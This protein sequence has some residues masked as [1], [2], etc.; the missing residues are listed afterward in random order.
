MNRGSAE[1]RKEFIR[2]WEAKEREAAGGRVGIAGL[3]RDFG[4]GLSAAYRWVAVYQQAGRKL[5]ALDD[6]PRRAGLTP[7][8]LTDEL[9][10]LVVNARKRNPRSGPERLRAWLL[11]RHPSL[12][13]PN[14]SKISEILSSHGLVAHAPRARPAPPPLDPPL[15]APTG[16]NAVW[17]LDVDTELETANGTRWRPLA[18]V[19]GFSQLCLRCDLVNEQQLRGMQ[20]IFD[21]AFR[22][23]GLPRAVRSANRPPF[24]STAPVGLT[25][26][27]I[28]LMRLGLRLER[29][30]KP[31]SAASARPDA[32]HAA[33]QRDV[34]R[35]R[36]ANRT[37]LQRALDL[38]RQAY[39]AR[40]QPALRG[41]SPADLY[42]P[43]S[44]TFPRSLSGPVQSFIG[45]NFDVDADGTITWG[46]KRI[47]IAEVLAGKS[48]Y[49][50]PDDGSRWEVCYD[51]LTIGH[52]DT[53]HLDRGF[54]PRPAPRKSHFLRL[55]P[56]LD[57]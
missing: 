52:I 10:A 37:A 24:T 51:Y 3:A 48:I 49:A 5:S 12:D 11:E 55:G 15:A 6:L 40:P 26:T 20:R 18:I 54:R 33:L 22:E 47:A 29:I 21:S 45:H 50:E 41:K 14:E 36:H 44:E 27:A 38:F 28:W 42:I 2:A 4:V 30:Q 57:E 32:F 23:Y 46:R 53:A 1:R 35:E 56:P 31:R 19:D 43:S 16:P 17:M 25:H 7:A 39:N 9:H 13:I 8:A 34:G